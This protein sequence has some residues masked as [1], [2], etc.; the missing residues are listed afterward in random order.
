MDWLWIAE[1]QGTGLLVRD[2]GL[3]RLQAALDP[4]EPSSIL[5]LRD[6]CSATHVQ[7]SHAPLDGANGHLELADLGEVEILDA[8]NSFRPQSASPRR[9]QGNAAPITRA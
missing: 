5:S 6:E 8:A 9:R 7:L 1:L 4:V 2:R 3:A